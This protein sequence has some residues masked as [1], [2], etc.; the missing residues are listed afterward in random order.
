M[1]DEDL[2]V[3]VAQRQV[4]ELDL[5]SLKPP[6]DLRQVFGNPHPVSLEIGIGKG[7]FLMRSGLAKPQ[8]NFLGIEYARKYLNRARERIEKRPIRNVRV[9]HA[10]AMSFM[11]DWLI[12]DSLKAIHLYFPDPWPKK[13]HHKRRI[14]NQ[15]FLEAC[16]RLLVTQGDLL[17]ATDHADYWAWMCDVLAKQ[18]LFVPS[19]LETLGSWLCRRGFLS[20]R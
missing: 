13:R 3:P 5:N 2:I 19:D 14:F 10:E 18:T 9:V 11:Q 15:V 17:I 4:C 12:P 6:L 16:Y 20:M 8:E 1:A 7:L